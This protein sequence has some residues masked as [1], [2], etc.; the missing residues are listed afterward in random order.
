[1]IV[2]PRVVP[3]G[4]G[5]RSARPRGDGD[6]GRG[7]PGGI[8][9]IGKQIGHYAIVGHLG[10]GGM[11]T[12]YKAHQI[13]LDR[14]VALKI[15]QPALSADEIIVKRFQQEARIAASLGHPRI[16]TIYDVGESDGLFYI[17]MR[18][19]DG[20]TLGQLLRREGPLEPG[21]ALNMIGQVAEALDFAHERGV[22]HRDVKPANVLVE[23][24]E[25]MTLTDFGIARASEHSQLTATHM[26]IGTPEY[27][28]PEQARGD[29]VDKRA[30][31]YAL[32]VLLYEA[33]GGRPPFSGASTPSLL[34]LHVHEAP[35]PIQTLRSDLPAALGAVL[36]KAL[37]K[38][39]ED[40]FA[41]AHEL[42]RAAR[43]AFE[44]HFA[45]ARTDPTI[46]AERPT[47]PRPTPP[48]SAPSAPG[49]PP[50]GT[51]PVQ[52]PVSSVPATPAGAGAA[53]A[54]Q[55]RPAASAR[56]LTPPPI[57]GQQRGRPGPPAS[58]LRMGPGTAVTVD[59]AR[60]RAAWILGPAVVVIAL[61]AVGAFVL[62]QLGVVGP[63]GETTPTPAPAKV[64]AAPAVTSGPAVTAAPPPTAPPAPATVTPAAP[65][66]ATSPPATPSPQQRLQ[67]ARASLEAGDFVQAL[68]LLNA[69]KQTDPATP[70]L[71][72]ALYQAH[73][74]YGKALLDQGDF[75]HGYAEYTEALQ[76]KPADG[77]A[78]DGQKQA[79]LAKNW[80]RMEASWGK[81]DEAAIAAL[82]EIMQVDAG[83]RDTRAK[84]YALLVAKA[85]RLLGAGDRDGALPVLMRA[86]EVNPD[87]AEARQRLASYTPTPAPVRPA[88]PP[89]APP[90][91]PPA[92]APQPAPQ[93]PG[94]RPFVPPGKPV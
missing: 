64:T 66:T 12:V 74:G 53:S 82:E 11:A 2:P 20:E 19:I 26:V 76:L 30:D 42:V 35:P 3:V 57:P 93:P 94:E 78:M 83:Y 73:I 75:D 1:M 68:A 17:A 24:G 59:Q 70:G 56:T 31:L 85:D 46:P 22:L 60:P 33:L 16:V 55:A 41:T 71:D 38:A 32:G 5:Y 23:A 48:W 58:T 34:Y 18:F 72:D 54:S 27:M 36:H 9:L 50:P 69:I 81:D 13:G 62:Y 91:A 4:A 92:P 29:P 28:S 86:L 25:Q 40:R 79:V 87:G 44:P 67:T 49:T 88:P 65:P 61:V 51:A 90:A 39:P 80:A 10:R 77:A 6:R 63:Q 21:R 45:S 84:L 15:L 8:D 47:T 7:S 89:A 43:Q 14:S 52:G 37:A